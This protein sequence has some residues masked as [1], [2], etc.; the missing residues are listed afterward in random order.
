MVSDIS[1]NLGKSDD[2]IFYRKGKKVRMN[3]STLT[4]GKSYVVVIEDNKLVIGEDYVGNTGTTRASHMALRKDHTGLY[5]RDYLGRGGA[6]RVNT[7]GSVDVSG[8][9][10]MQKD[11]N[12]AKRIAAKLKGALGNVDIRITGDRLKTLD[13][14]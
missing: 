7:D 13:P 1:T 8:Y 14:K 4:P 11:L 3:A 12:A 6:I 10:I 2:I 5:D 9:H